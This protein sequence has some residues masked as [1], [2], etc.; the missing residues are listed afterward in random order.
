MNVIEW[1]RS[2]KPGLVNLQNAK[3]IPALF[4]AAQMCHESSL[5]GGAGL[6]ELALKAHN[7][8]GLK[9]A[10]WERDYGCEPVTYGTWEVLNG[11]RVD[12]QDAF[13]KAPSWEVWLQLYG[14][15]LTGKYYGGALNY[16]HDPFLY[17]FHIW[18]AGWATDPAYL[19]ALAGWISQLY[20]DYA[21]TIPLAPYQVVPIRTGGGRRLASGLLVNGSTLAPARRLAESLGQKVDW[22][23]GAVIVDPPGEA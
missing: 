3:G 10:E 17:G 11:Q 23:D 19:T 16:R 9:W 20:P 15:L 6:S 4:S 2:V 21:D 22:K 18:Q 5:P 13:C 14:D 8:A 7:Y 12:L 1:A